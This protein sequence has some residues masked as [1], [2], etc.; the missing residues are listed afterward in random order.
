MNNIRQINYWT[1]G[2]FEGAKPPEQALEEAAE[3]GYTGVE[4]AF[5]GGEF[6][7]G[8]SEDR[9]KEI[10]KAAKRLDMKIA[11]LASGLFWR[12]RFTDTR[13]SKRK[14]VIA[15]TREYLHVAKWVGAKAVLVIPGAV[16]V[17]WESDAPLVSYK[18][19][20]KNATSALRQCVPVAKKLGVTMAIENVWNRFLTDPVAMKHFVDQFNTRRVGVYLDVANCLLNGYPEH[21][22]EIL[23]RRIAAVHFKN[24]SREDC[25]G[26][27]HGFGDDLLE[28]DVDWKAVIKTLKRIKYKGPITAEMIP[29]SRL[30]NLELPDMKMAGDTAGKLNNLLGSSR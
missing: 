8:I 30:P 22:I 3:M 7:P 20:W 24:F 15:F 21:W 28:G 9:C 12:Y 23:G 27:L 18:E 2:G 11:T 26:V 13:A 6:G 10:K 25:G 17:P 5:D 1:I 14:K 4:L 29:F 16:A 19:A